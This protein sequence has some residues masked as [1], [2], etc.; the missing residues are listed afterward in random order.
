MFRRLLSNLKFS[1]QAFRAIS[2]TAPGASLSFYDP[3]R[4]TVV[5]AAQS[6]YDPRVFGRYDLTTQRPEPIDST[7]PRALGDLDLIA[8][9]AQ[10][11]RKRTERKLPLDRY[12]LVM[13]NL[14]TGA[15]LCLDACTNQPRE[16]V[17]VEVT[18]RGYQ[19]QAIDITGNGGTVLREDLTNLT[20]ADRS[21]SAIISL[22]TLEHIPNYQKALSE[23]YRVLNDDGLAILHVPCYY[24]EKPRSEP[25]ADGVDPFGHVYYLSAREI[26]TEID[27]VGFI[28]LRAHFNF[29]YGA[30]LCIAGKHPEVKLAR[31]A[32]S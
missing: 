7:A 20:L 24:F 1:A 25:I 10:R 2:R 4:E 22:D 27:S 12:S 31:P 17:S 13:A 18:A 21:V 15:G 5:P 3:S 11:H 8:G 29:D 9:D 26:L 19:Y 32:T 28:V 30:L 14:P 6:I 23:M 16:E